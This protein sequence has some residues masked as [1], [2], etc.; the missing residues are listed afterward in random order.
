MLIYAE[1]CEAD[2]EETVRYKEEEPVKFQHSCKEPVGAGAEA[3][4]QGY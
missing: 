4:R 3:E 1:F 2:D